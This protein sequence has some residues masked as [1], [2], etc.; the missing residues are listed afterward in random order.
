MP[1]LHTYL[2]ARVHGDDYISLLA[3]AAAVPRP[4][5][6]SAAPWPS[7]SMFCIL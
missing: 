6:A 1:R 5:Q 4:A 7:L 3:A 2:G